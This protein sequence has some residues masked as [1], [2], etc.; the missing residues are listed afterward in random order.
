[1]VGAYY[2]VGHYSMLLAMLRNLPRS[3]LSA[4]KP[5]TDLTEGAA[6][7]VGVECLRNIEL[8]LNKN[9]V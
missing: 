6:G 5:L 8:V 7:G 4:G 3:S 2:C 1:M 9:L